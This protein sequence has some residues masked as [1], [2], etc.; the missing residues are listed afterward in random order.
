MTSRRRT[1]WQ[2]Q[3]RM[4]RWRKNK[5]NWGRTRALGARQRRRTAVRTMRLRADRVA[6]WRPSVRLAARVLLL[7]TSTSTLSR[8]F[9]PSQR[10]HRRSGAAQGR[11]RRD[12][13]VRLQLP[14]C[15]VDCAA[16]QARGARIEERGTFA[17]QLP[18]LL[19]WPAAAARQRGRLAVA[20]LSWSSPDR[21][22]HGV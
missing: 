22:S 9:L 5:T 21:V 12:Q 6:P 11:Q 8:L 7:T 20:A 19:M 15:R 2:S 17:Q 10:G 1:P 4:P 14:W 3:A 18:S 13:S 16:Q